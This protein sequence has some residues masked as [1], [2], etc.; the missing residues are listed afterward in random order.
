MSVD[1]NGTVY[2]TLSE[3]TLVM[4][5]H[6]TLMSHYVHRNEF[7]GTIDLNSYEPMVEAMVKHGMQVDHEKISA[8]V[9]KRQRRYY[10]IPF[11]SVM[12]KMNRRTQRKINAEINKK[13]KA[14]KESGL[15]I[16]IEVL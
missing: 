6:P 4:G 7:P 9:N 15:Q 13:K 2:L 11:T 1:I 14:L 16:D 5:I 12:D 3:A 8:S 10:L